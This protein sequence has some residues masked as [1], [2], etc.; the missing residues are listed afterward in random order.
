MPFDGQ[1]PAVQ[2]QLDLSGGKWPHGQDIGLGYHRPGE[3]VGPRGDHEVVSRIAAD[4]PL[5][6]CSD[7]AAVFL[8]C[9][10]IEAV[11]QDHALAA[12]Q[13]PLPPAI[14]LAAG[15]GSCAAASA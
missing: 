11:Q 10:L 13:L 7:G 1:I 4:Q 8:A 12:A 2:E 5:Y 15:S 6:P 9:D 3:S 14:G